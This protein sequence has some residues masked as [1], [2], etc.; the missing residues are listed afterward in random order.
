MSDR[1][2]QETGLPLVFDAKVECPAGEPIG[3]TPR[4]SG[5]ACRLTH[6]AITSQENPRALLAFCCS[7]KYRRCPVWEA[8][9]ERIAAAR[10][11]ALVEA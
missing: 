9:C 11:E 4:G 1:V 3:E 8:E 6:T 5:V 10:R 7:S 2:R